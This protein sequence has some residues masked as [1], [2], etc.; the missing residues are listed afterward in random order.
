[1]EEE[2]K[3]ATAEPI[4]SVNEFE[5]GEF[6]IRE[7][8]EWGGSERKFAGFHVGIAE[9]RDPNT[10]Q[11][12]GKKPAPYKFPIEAKTIEEAFDKFEESAKAYLE[13]RNKE[14]V[15]KSNLIMKS[16]FMLGDN[17]GG[18]RFRV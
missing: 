18:S 12:V 9:I 15:Q 17:G 4:F 11:L 13:E 10:N 14:S 3:E 6:T 1:M 8:V 16:G 2:K 5:R 7:S